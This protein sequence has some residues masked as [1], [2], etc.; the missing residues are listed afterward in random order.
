MLNHMLADRAARRRTLAAACAALTAL[1]LLVWPA[2]RP[3]SLTEPVMLATDKVLAITPNTLRSSR[4]VVPKKKNYIWGLYDGY[5]HNPTWCAD[6]E[7]ASKS[8]NL[9]MMHGLSGNSDAP[10]ACSAN[11]GRRYRSLGFVGIPKVGS[12]FTQS[13]LAA[14]GM[15]QVHST[16]SAPSRSHLTILPFPIARADPLED[17]RRWRRV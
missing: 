12:L 13:W 7:P 4:C 5:D 17:G 16:P 3:R 8:I 15:N 9:F 10:E 1:A 11:A 14:V 2:A 6:H